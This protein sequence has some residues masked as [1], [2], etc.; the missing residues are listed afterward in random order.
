[1]MTPRRLL[2]NVLV[3]LT[4]IFLL[5]CPPK[6]PAPGD[7]PV[8][9]P[10]KPTYVPLS[11]RDAG[12]LAGDLSTGLQDIESWSAMRP[13]LEK[14]LRYIENRPPNAVCVHKPGLTLTWGQLRDS[15]AELIALLPEIDNDPSLLAERFQWLKLEPGTLLTG[16]YEPWLEASLTPDDEYP[17]PLYEVPEDL[18]KLDLGKFHYRWKGQTLVYQMG[19]D[20]IEP[21]H[22]REAIDRNRVLEGMGHEI[23][24][25]KNPVDV[26]FLQ[27]QGSGRLALPDGSSKHILY[28]G[29]NGRKYVS[30][31]RLLIERGYVPKEE[32]SMQRIRAFLHNNR[33]IAW[34]LMFDNPSYV[35][36]SLSDEGPFGSIGSI[37]M[38][39]VSVAV[40]RKTI[41][42]GSVLAL[43]TAL[44]DY[45]SGESE[46]FLSLVLAQDT[47]G[48][49]KGTRMDLFCGSGEEAELLAGHLQ[50]DSEVF[51]LMSKRAL[52][53]EKWEE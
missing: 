37:L 34:E 2:C 47:G 48:A 33:D 53:F 39:K 10:E 6:T 29:K 51:M 4:F 38:P 40:D 43:K 36:F 45:D 21:Y 22:D 14:S 11:D 49:I 18:R 26:F 41:P 25:A 13:A 27:I 12:R 3:L 17:F 5:G 46:L 15:V 28:G 31:G 19:E 24:W 42:L 50:E 9:K 30:L 35:F 20:G 23:A 44:M 32:M 8:A 52:K 7:K 1:M 16:Y